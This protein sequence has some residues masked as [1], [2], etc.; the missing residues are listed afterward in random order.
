VNRGNYWDKLDWAADA[1]RFQFRVW[2]IFFGGQWEKHLMGG[3]FF[4]NGR[5]SGIQGLW[6]LGCNVFFALWR[7]KYSA[8][9][10]DGA[11][12]GVCEIGHRK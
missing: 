2:Q 7:A 11:C 3:K 6:R 12:E 1:E 10:C 8:F 5:G 9:F 4:R